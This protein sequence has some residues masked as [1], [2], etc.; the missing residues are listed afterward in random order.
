MSNRKQPTITKDT[1]PEGFTLSLALLDA[2]PVLL[3]AVAIVLLGIKA[4]MSPLII[5]GGLLCFIGG[6]IKVLWKVIVA[7]KQK[8]VWWMFVQMRPMMLLGFLLLLVGCVV[9][10]HALAAAFSGI[11]AVSIV[12]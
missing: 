2:V 7:V 1:V 5:L 9:S 8:N 10:R 11:R 4:S 3:F 6:A 12:C